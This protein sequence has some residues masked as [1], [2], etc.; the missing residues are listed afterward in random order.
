MR[1]FIKTFFA[2]FTGMLLFAGVAVVVTLIIVGAAIS[3]GGAKEPSVEDKTVLVFDISTTISDTPATSDLRKTALDRVVGGDGDSLPL[4]AALDAID[5]AAKDKRIVG[6]YLHGNLS[7]E[8]Y[9]SGFAA[10]KEVREAL[11]RFKASKKPIIAYNES[12]AERDYYL[13]SVADTCVLNP[14]GVLEMNGLASETMFLGDAFKK[15]GVGVQVTRVGKYKS[16][17]EPYILNKMSPENREQI[18]KLLGDLWTEYLEG[19]AK[20]RNL[21]ADDLRKIAD[22]RGLL[23]GEQAVERKLADKTAY[24]DQ[25]MA[26]LKKLTG[27]DEGDKTFRQVNLKTYARVSRK[28]LGLERESKNRI[29]VVYAEGAIVDGTGSDDQVGGDRLSRQLRDL[30]QDPDVKAVVLRVNSPGGSALASELIQ[31]EL[32][33]MREAKKPVIVSMGTVAASGGYWIS[34]ASDRIFAEPNTITGS[35]GVFGVLPN[36]GKL[37]NDYGVTWDTVKTNKFSDLGTLVRPKTDEELAVLQTLVDRIYDQFL[38]RVSEA[39]KLPKEK[40]NEIA[41]GRVWSGVQAKEIGLVDEIGGLEAAVKYAADQAK[42]GGDWKFV[43]YPERRSLTDKLNELLSDNGEP[44]RV[45]RSPLTK[46]VQRVRETFATFAELNDP[47][48]VYARMPFNL[49]ID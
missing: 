29:A 7:S 3:G 1:D 32:V 25:V 18:E 22:E 11:E 37:A 28:S 41:Q 34:T 46:E 45:V 4:S 10:L 19:V 17:V 20:S 23:V 27:K 40:V 5:K 26:D 33:L 36:V 9:G 21:T 6:L 48:H 2:S 24:F 35:I 12:Y 16:A 8:N 30:R 47:M 43:E 49:R 38:T 31:R 44:N 14:F 39:R 13:A 15:Y 42:L